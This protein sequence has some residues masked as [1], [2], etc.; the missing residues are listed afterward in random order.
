MEIILQKI[1][2]EK[3]RGVTVYGR[4]DPYLVK[5]NGLVQLKKKKI[6]KIKIKSVREIESA[7]PII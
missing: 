6:I 3:R 7:D 5:H 2:L 4:R 1:D